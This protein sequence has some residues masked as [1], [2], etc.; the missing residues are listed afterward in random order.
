M[1]GKNQYVSVGDYLCYA[2]QN[3][4]K[5][6]VFDTDLYLPVKENQI[7]SQITQ[8]KMYPALP[9]LQCSAVVDHID[10]TISSLVVRLLGPT[11]ISLSKLGMLS[12]LWGSLQRDRL[13][14]VGSAHFQRLVHSAGAAALQKWGWLSRL[15]EIFYHYFQ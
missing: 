4:W 13:Q 12:D 15:T 6:L 11:N 9:R 8:I 10:P 3:A 5:R 7:M 14:K 1:N 2:S